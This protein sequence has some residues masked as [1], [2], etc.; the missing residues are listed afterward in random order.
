MRLARVVGRS[1]LGLMTVAAGTALV[2]RERDLDDRQRLSRQLARRGPNAAEVE[3]FHPEQVAGLPA[4]ARRYFLR[5]IAPGT[6]LA[7]HVELEMGGSIRLSPDGAW[8]PMRARQI[9][10]PPSGFVWEATVG[11]G[12]LRFSGAD[13]YAD[14]RGE[15]RFQAWG[16]VPFVRAGGPDV[17]RS[18]R[19]RLAGEAVWNP[20]AL[21][22]QRGV[23]WE[24]IDER[25]ARAT[26][27]I[28][29]EPL[30]LTVTVEDDGRLA[31]VSLMRW[32]DRTDDGTYG[33]VPFGVN[34]LGEG[35]FGGYTI[36]T[37]I[38]G[39][40]WFGTER[41]F[42]LARFEIERASFH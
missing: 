2:A 39:G 16:L 27:T 36:P 21:L 17:A 1:V 34:V 29:G 4:P 13:S 42:E 35:R 15:V 32:G 19:G 7:H 8:M 10:A 6:P 3:H 20:A 30:T 22:P 12:A 23:T 31:S 33:L 41:Y 28:D 40:W 38:G 37:R 26:M 14:G 25:S 5:A 9:L 24:P 11:Q 18:A